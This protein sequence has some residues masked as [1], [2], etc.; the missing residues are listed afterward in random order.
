VVI[1]TEKNNTDNNLKYIVTPF[2][3]LT[4]MFYVSPKSFF[5]TTNRN[6][7]SAIDFLCFLPDECLKNFLH[8]K[9]TA[10]NFAFKNGFLKL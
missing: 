2:L 9:I 4:S 3:V 10:M 1:Q 5:K 8:I 6:T 7:N